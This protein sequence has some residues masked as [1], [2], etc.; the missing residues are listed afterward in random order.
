MPDEKSYAQTAFMYPEIAIC[1]DEIDR[2][3]PGTKRFNIPA[4]TPEM[5]Q[6][7]AV[8]K[9]IRQRKDNILNET[10]NNLNISE[11]TISNYIM[12]PI[13]RE[14]VSVP[15]AGGGYSN[16]YIGKI[17][18]N[19]EGYGIGIGEGNGVGTGVGSGVGTG[20]GT[21]TG[22]TSGSLTAAVDSYSH[23]GSTSGNLDVETSV[24]TDVYTDVNTDVHTDVNTEVY[25]DIY[26]KYDKIPK[27]SKWI[28]VFIGGDVNKAR[29]IAPYID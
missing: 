4:L 14:L 3:N 22:S 15:S 27:G 21:G 28:V 12:I 26:L 19:G 13:P 10:S 8:D 2:R 29:I 9:K 11:V 20:D 7:N 1:L 24:T 25:T 5:N 23:K 16:K 6:S 17:K 18:G